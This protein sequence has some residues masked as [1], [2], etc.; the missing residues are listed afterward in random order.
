MEN[1]QPMVQQKPGLTSANGRILLLSYHFAPANT[2]GAL[3][4]TQMTHLAWER[5][6]GVDAIALP[7]N[8]AEQLEPGA[9]EELP[10]GTRVYGVADLPPWPPQIEQTLSHLT[11]K[12]RRSRTPSGVSAASD[13]AEPTT[14][15]PQS[16][17]TDNLPRGLLQL[18]TWKRAYM[19]IHDY[20]RFWGWATRSEQLAHRI[21]DPK[22][23]RLILSCGPPHMSHNGARRL[24]QE[25][26]LPFVMDLRDP[27]SLINRLNAETASPT[28][29]RLARLF[30]LRAVQN[31]ALVV[32]NTK[33]ARD[34]MR[35]SYPGHAKKFIYVM[36]GFDD[37]SVPS[38]EP[39]SR[40]SI[41]Y[42][43]SIYLDRSPR[44]FFRAVAR[45]VDELDLSPQHLRVQLM[46]HVDRM[47]GIPVAE[48]ARQ[49]GIQDFLS[50]RPPGTRR[51]AAQFLASAS[52]LISLPQDSHLA[53]PSKVFDYMRYA[54]WVLVL[55][56][57]GSATELIL[58]DTIADVVHPDDVDCISE[59][60]RRRYKEHQAGVRPAAIADP[61]FSRRAQADRLFDAIARIR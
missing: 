25:T 11:R 49:E 28:W 13:S 57:T 42:A 6:W 60:I 2:A 19:S 18:R 17:R 24:S 30:E 35:N 52:M 40:F 50:L 41:C 1:P 61:R 48:I 4:W 32:M 20:A 54:A 23:H 29:L 36:N 16:Y 44:T 10:S 59:V 47:D 55:A 58:R 5:G 8:Q 9:L 46:G 33:P 22:L 37:A 15:P 12:R 26:G 21:I 34:A 43:G 38:V 53:I 7:A 3:R 45:T 27:W 14:H 56:E 39:E 51:E 31:A